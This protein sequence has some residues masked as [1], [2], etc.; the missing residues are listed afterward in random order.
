MNKPKNEKMLN[1]I[2]YGLTSA[3]L[4][5]TYSICISAALGRGAVFALICAVIC[6]LFS[7]KGKGYI[8]APA[9]LLILP[10]YVFTQSMPVFYCSFAILG[11]GIICLALNLIAKKREIPSCIITGGAIGL[12]IGATIMLTNIYFSIGSFGGTALEMLKNYRYLGFHPDFRGLLFGTITLFTMITYPFKFRK[13]N[14]Y[15]PAEFIT[16][17]IPFIINLLLNSNATTT[18]TSEYT[19]ASARAI[20]STDFTTSPKIFDVMGATL[21][22]GLIFYG[23]SKAKDKLFPIANMTTG[24]LSGNAV[25]PYPVRGYTG[26]SAAT[27]IIVCSA[28]IFLFPSLISRLPL[29]CVGAMLIVSAW[30]HVPFGGITSTI[31]EKSIVKVIALILCAV[32][33]IILSAPVA[34]VLCAVLAIITS[35]ISSHSR[36]EEKA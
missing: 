28:V 34:T 24:A 17:L 23:F 25:A 18:T 13:L 21:A 15:L 35:K 33:F 30:Q 4:I 26:I 7:L 12:A 16:I 5:G 27:V 32:S 11:G 31:K 8:L 2:G 29:P 6:A 1:Q 10:L 19:F 20:L 22:M 9:S 14:K 36:R 3:A